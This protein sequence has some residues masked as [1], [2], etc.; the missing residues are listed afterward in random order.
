M[1]RKSGASRKSIKSIERLEQRVLLGAGS[2]DPLGTSVEGGG[3]SNDVNNSYVPDVAVSGSKVFVA[4]NDVPETGD[5]EI[6]VKVWDG[7]S[8]GELGG[9]ATGGGI[10]NDDVASVLPS[11]W[12]DG[13]GNPW[14]TWQSGTIQESRIYVKYWD[15]DSWEQAAGSATGEGISPISGLGKIKYAEMPEFGSYNGKP[16]VAWANV[17]SGTP[18]TPYEIFAKYWDAGSWKELGGS[19]SGGGISGNL[20][21]SRAPSLAKLPDGNPVVAWQDTSG[22]FPEVYLKKWSGSA[23]VEIAGSASGRGL[24]SAGGTAYPSV[25]VGKTADDITVSFMVLEG[26]FFA[27]YAKSLFKEDS[28]YWWDGLADSDALGGL[29]KDGLA[30]ALTP[31]TGY[32]SAGNPIVVWHQV[33]NNS[34]FGKVW[35][36]SAT[37]WEELDQSASPGGLSMTPGKFSAF[38]AMDIKPDGQPVVAWTSSPV[39]IDVKAILAELGGAVGGGSSEIVLAA[40]AEEDAEIYLRE[41]NAII[42]H[43]P[44]AN[45]MNVT[46]TESTNKEITLDASDVDLDPLTFQILVEP[47]NGNLILDR[48]DEGIVTYDPLDHYDGPDS[49]TYRVTDDDGLTDDATVNITVTDVNEAPWV[50]DGPIGRSVNPSETVHVVLPAFDEESEVIFLTFIITDPPD[51]GTLTPGLPGGDF[52]YAA[53]TTLGDDTFKYKVRDPQGLE[54][55]EKQVLIHIGENRPPVATD[56]NVTTPANTPVGITLEAVD[57]DWWDVLTFGSPSTPSQGS[58]SGSG[59]SYTYTP[60][61]DWEGTTSFT[62]T[63]NDGDATDT[64]TITITVGAPVNQAPNGTIDTPTDGTTIDPGQSINLTGTGTD[65]DGTIAAWAWAITGPQNFSYTT[66]DPGNLVLNTPGTYTITFTVTDDDGA[67]DASPDTATVTVRG[68]NNPPN[69]AINT[70]TDGTTI[71]PGQSINLTGTGTDSDGTIAEWAWLVTGP[72]GFSQ[73]YTVEDPGNLTLNTPGTYTITFVTTDDDGADDPSP[74]VINVIVRGANNP[75]N[76]TIDSPSG[77]TTID[78][79]QAINLQGSGTDSDGT[80]VAWAWLVTGPSG[81]N[82]V[83]AVEDPGNLTLNTPG[84][85]TVTLTVTDDDFAPDPTPAVATVTVNTP[86]N[87]PPNGIIDS[88][89]GGTTIDPGQAINLQGSGT[90][91]DGTI[92]AW[93]WLVVGPSSFS[94]A[95]VVQD[96]GNL[97]LNTPGIYTVT[98]TVTDDDLTVDPTPAIVTVT[99]NAPNTPPVA[100]NGNATVA[101]DGTVVVNLNATDANG[102]PMT[103]A[104]VANPGHGTLDLGSPA[105]DNTLTYIPAANWFGT[106]TFTFKANDGEADSNVATITVTVNPVND[107]PVA[108]DGLT[109]TPLDTAVDVNLVATDIDNAPGDLTYSITIPPA[110]GTVTLTGNVAHYTPNPGYTGADTF[111]FGASDLQPL[112]DTGVITVRVGQAWDLLGVVNTSAGNVYIYDTDGTTNGI[113]INGDYDETD[114]SKYNPYDSANDLLIIGTP[115]GVIIVAN[116]RVKNGTTWQPADFSALGVVVDG[117]LGVFADQRMGTGDISFLSAKTGIGTAIVNSHLAGMVGGSIDVPNGMVIPEGA[118]L[119]APGQNIGTVIVYGAGDSMPGNVIAKDLTTFITGG[120]FSGDI[121]LTGKAGLIYTGYKGAA[122]LDGDVS[123]A[124]IG[125]FYSKGPVTGDVTTTGGAELIYATGNISGDMDIGGVVGLYYT[126]AN[127]T[128]DLNA[129][130]NIKLYYVAGNA[131]GHVES[132][133]DIAT[134]FTKGSL[135]GTGSVIAGGNIGTMVVGNGMDT[136]VQAAK[137]GTLVVQKGALDGQLDITGDAS[138]IISSAGDILATVN[139]GG[140]LGMIG[141]TNNVFRGRIDAVKI[142]TFIAKGVGMNGGQRSQIIG[143][144]GIKNLFVMGDVDGCDIGV[145]VKSLA[146][147][148]TVELG[149]V[150]VAGSLTRS[151]V[152]AG[153]RNEP[154]PSGPNDYFSDGGEDATPYIPAGF[155]GTAKIVNGWIDDMTG[156]VGAPPNQWAIATKDKGLWSADKFDPE[157]LGDDYIIDDD[158]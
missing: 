78:P 47:E 74:A 28:T 25:A 51:L 37:A 123:A 35:D 83:Y 139:V 103:Y 71:D 45:D 23:W 50:P 68:V 128:G 31:S 76:G 60:P 118:A 10:S 116:A 124:S 114:G 6:Y 98:L 8:W 105:N 81:F 102:D 13:S 87:H 33:G 70:P 149:Y 156:S 150:Y 66:E 90:D 144:D 85:Y 107:A 127:A 135:T 21:T 101:E 14:V 88:P 73:A 62:F 26:D 72:G 55:A 4:W 34:I 29:S 11:I 36:P 69:S 64:G 143:N 110:H 134:L 89:L 40:A 17:N 133:K 43:P 75:P 126:T 125:T 106:D 117:K 121:T 12:V 19:A 131:S 146:A 7:A 16:M 48:L 96:P 137:L 27:V 79:G 41:F 5:S 141:A 109:N 63:V 56:E 3:I 57:L 32:D 92:I 20:G 120:G 138:T 80:I 99:V 9:S 95:Y 154:N 38:P 46:V 1:S 2:W 100:S 158:V 147:G 86:G 67:P 140:T 44:V 61:T 82:Q 52:L 157:Y 136:N 53:G 155:A 148:K 130:G 42:N 30:D 132:A 84:T 142:G 59:T 18:T 152:L 113:P 151:N 58:L 91:D 115:N 39:D 119:Y 122:S 108:S 15:G 94:Q 129:G 145:G 22:G 77:G 49:F 153:C 112:H 24:S 97:T 65:T 54:S 93:A 104:I 111:T